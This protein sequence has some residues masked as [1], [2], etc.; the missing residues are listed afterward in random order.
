MGNRTVGDSIR[1]RDMETGNGLFCGRIDEA[2]YPHTGGRTLKRLELS[3]IILDV[4]LFAERREEIFRCDS[5]LA[6]VNFFC[7]GVV[8]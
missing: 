6:P 5:K 3:E 2:I 7:A 4:I 1:E 8:V